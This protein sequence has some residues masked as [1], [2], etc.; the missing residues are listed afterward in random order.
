MA[1]FIYHP[2]EIGVNEKAIYR[3]IRIVCDVCYTSESYLRFRIIILK[4]DNS[5]SFLSALNNPTKRNMFSHT[6][7]MH[8]NDFT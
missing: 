3:K 2:Y 4:N 7:F 8:I 5:F 6:I 1:R